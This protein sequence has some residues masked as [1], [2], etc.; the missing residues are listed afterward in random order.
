MKY[1]G[2]YSPS[3]LADPVRDDVFESYNLI[4]VFLQMQEEYTWFPLRDCILQLE[5][6]RYAT[7]AHPEHSVEGSEDPGEGMIR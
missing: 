5:K 1:K 7:F 3:Y 6:F 2:E 4:P